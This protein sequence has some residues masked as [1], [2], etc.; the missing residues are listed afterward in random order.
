VEK[1][2]IHGNPKAPSTPTQSRDNDLAQHS[3]REQ[4]RAAEAAEEAELMF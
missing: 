2:A 4:E 3:M 1:L